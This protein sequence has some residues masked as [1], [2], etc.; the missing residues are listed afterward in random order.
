MG[1]AVVEATGWKVFAELSDIFGCIEEEI[2]GVRDGETISVVNT[3]D[4]E[5]RF[6]GVVGTGATEGGDV[7]EGAGKN[8]STEIPCAVLGAMAVTVTGIGVAVGCASVDTGDWRIV[9]GVSES[10][11]VI[12]KRL[13]A[14]LSKGEKMFRTWYTCNA[15]DVE[16]K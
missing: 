15:S 12:P 5:T 9:L 7:L 13:S 2:E 3:G 11:E 10:V 6:E 1:T 8:D 14:K 4:G 16:V